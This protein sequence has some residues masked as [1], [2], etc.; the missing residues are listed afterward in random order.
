MTQ[1]ASKAKTLMSS[2]Y[3]FNFNGKALDIPNFDNGMY[4]LCVGS[5]GQGDQSYWCCFRSS[6]EIYKHKNGELTHVGNLNDTTGTDGDTLSGVIDGVLVQM[7]C[8]V[9]A[10]FK[11]IFP[12]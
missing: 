3:Y 9:R 8:S 2:D 10:V 11:V 5:S 4:A 6:Y 12:K 1:T 7:S